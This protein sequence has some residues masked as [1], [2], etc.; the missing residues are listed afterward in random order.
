[1]NRLLIAGAATLV[2]VLGTTRAHAGYMYLEWMDCNPTYKLWE[3]GWRGPWSGLGG[4]HLDQA[5]SSAGPWKRVQS[6]VPDDGCYFP[7]ENLRWY[8]L[9][10]PKFPLGYQTLAS[11]WVPRS[12][13]STFRVH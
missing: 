5:T 8:R 13:C 9:A 3:V 6:F 11:V 4:K 12:R 2:L 7:A 1:M 10:K